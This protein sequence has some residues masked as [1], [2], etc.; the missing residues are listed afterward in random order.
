MFHIFS[1]LGL[2]DQLIRGI[3]AAGYSSPTPIQTVAI[4][5]ALTGKTAAFILPILHHLSEA[6]ETQNKLYIRALV[7]TP[8]RELAQQIEDF[9]TGY[10]RFSSIKSLPIY[11]GVSMDKQL[12]LLRRG[13]DIVI[14]T[15]GRLIDHIKRKTIDLSKVTHLVLD[16]ADRM[17]DMGFIDEVSEI[18]DR[19]P[20]DRQTLL[21]SATMSEDVMSLVHSYQKNPESIE[22]G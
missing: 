18:I 13:S 20:E 11:G 3:I 10:S 1:N 15:P 12:R 19:F 16:E 2:S 6:V 14:A 21:F 7:L 5:L 9:V 22:V 8:T 17:L 4:P